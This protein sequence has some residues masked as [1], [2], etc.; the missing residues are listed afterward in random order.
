MPLKPFKQNSNQHQQPVM[1]STFFVTSPIYYVNDTPHIGHAYTSTACDAIARF[2]R[3][4]NHE[5]FFL[6][7]TDEHGQKVEKSAV[8]RGKEPQQFCDEVSQKFRDLTLLLNLSNDDFI[9]TTEARHKQTVEKFWRI[10]EEKGWIYK[11]VYEGWYAV[12]DEAFYGED[13]IVDGKAP[14]GAEVAWHKEES[15]FFRL[16]AFQDKLLA[17]YEAA[18][19]FIRPASRLNEITNFV[20]SGLRDLSV[21]RN[22]FSWGIKVPGDEKNVVYVWL[23]A[24]VN[25]LSALGFG[26]LD[27]DSAKNS[28]YQKFWIDATKSPLHIVGKDIARFH[29][30][31]W[32]AFLMAAEINIPYGIYAHGWWTNEGQK[33]SKSLGNVIDPLKELEWLE[34][35]GCETATAI[36][37][38]RYFLLREVPFGNDGDYSRLH[39]L[40]RI[41]SE[42]ANNIGNLAQRS[43]TM[44]TAN[45]AGEIPARIDN[46]SESSSSSTN[47]EP[48]KTLIEPYIEA[49]FVAFDN[50]AFDKAINAVVEFASLVNKRFNDAAPWNLKKDGKIEEMKLVLHDAAESLRLIAI[51]L[52]PFI[53][54]SANRLL[55]LLAIPTSKRDFNHINDSIASGHKINAPK[56]LFPRLKA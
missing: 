8:A 50:L 21:S 25:Y 5:V 30:V 44:I 38:F 13:E 28:L 29:G 51:L 47:Q 17:L 36:D 37:Y 33:I 41:N 7:G 43:L 54:T 49:Y 22:S 39:L 32:P 4:Q 3:L 48:I 56:A 31:Y 53:P 6:T 16:S 1:T 55:D 46:L 20:K 40:G 42:L 23:D 45:C 2:Q 35:L 52:L 12:R 11:G 24:L 26:E 34:S 15:Y 19:D 9:R 27:A 14:T 18:P 10:L